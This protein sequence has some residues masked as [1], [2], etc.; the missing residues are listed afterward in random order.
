MAKSWNRRVTRAIWGMKE[1]LLSNLII[2][3]GMLCLHIEMAYKTDG[4]TFRIKIQ[5]GMVDF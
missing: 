5:L 4:Q 1:L 3:P 2:S